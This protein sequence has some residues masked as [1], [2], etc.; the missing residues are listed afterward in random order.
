MLRDGRTAYAK[1]GNDLPDRVP[2]VTQQSQDLSAGRHGGRPSLEM[3]AGSE[4]RPYRHRR[5][6][7]QSVEGLR[8]CDP[9]EQATF[10]N[11]R[12]E[13]MDINSSHCILQLITAIMQVADC[14]SQKTDS[15][16]GER[17]L[18][19]KMP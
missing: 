9:C 11:V 7:H 17:R 1:I 12:R 2:T 16:L 5:F 6:A 10:Y 4:I 3:G 13:E 14:S 18:A 8:I 15:P 19:Q